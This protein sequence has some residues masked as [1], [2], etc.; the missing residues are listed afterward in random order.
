MSNLVP[1]K[2]LSAVAVLD[3]SLEGWSLLDIPATAVRA[4][5]QPVRF[6][7]RFAAAPL[8]HVGIVGLDVSKED[9]LRIRL[10]ALDVTAEGFTLHAETWFNTR[11]WSV[12]VSWLAI[13]V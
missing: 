1:F 6:E 5:R 3:S 2:M 12:E 9:N 13:G 8:V 4:F 11:I 10:R 7:R